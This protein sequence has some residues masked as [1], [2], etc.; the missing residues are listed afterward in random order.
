MIIKLENKGYWWAIYLFPRKNYDC[1]GNFNG[2]VGLLSI[3]RFC[4]DF[5]QLIICFFNKIDIR[6]GKLNE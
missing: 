5:P 4:G 2:Y 6:I 3:S 1:Y